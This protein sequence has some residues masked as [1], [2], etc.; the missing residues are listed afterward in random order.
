MAYRRLAAAASALIFP[1]IVSGCAGSSG[2]G[3]DEPPLT[4]QETSSAYAL[5]PPTDFMDDMGDN[6]NVAM[7]VAGTVYFC[8][9]GAAATACSANPGD[10]VPNM[11]DMPG[12]PWAPFTGRPSA[13]FATDEG[14]M[15][16]V[17]EG[18]TPGSGE[19]HPGERLEYL[20]G[21]CQAPDEQSLEC[22]YNDHSFAISGPDKT[23]TEG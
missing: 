8:T 17:L 2:G 13:I 4:T 14:T 21:W 10:S 20:N 7:T 9:L 19:L 16:G 3:A 15:W 22:G 12:T 18:G 23:V 11:E 6:A 5:V 1:V